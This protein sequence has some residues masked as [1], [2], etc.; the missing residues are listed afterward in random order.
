MTLNNKNAIL[1][2]RILAYFIDFFLVC[3]L[4]MGMVLIIGIDK[5]NNNVFLAI[6][7]FFIPIIIYL[8]K[9][10]ANGKSVG[11]RLM[12]IKVVTKNSRFTSFKYILRNVFL[13]IW[14]VDW[15]FILFTRNR[16]RLGD[17][18]SGTIVDYD[19]VT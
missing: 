7:I 19:N 13:L 9:D 10:I 2:L 8:L 12:G 3:L 14:F 16:R 18:V 4:L 17:I 5:L 15:V 6:T 11:K 1:G